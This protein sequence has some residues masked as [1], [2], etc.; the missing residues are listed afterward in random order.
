VDQLAVASVLA[1]PRCLACGRA[2]RPSARLCDRCQPALAEARPGAAALRISEIRLEVRWAGEYAGV[3]RDL[4]VALK[5]ARRHAAAVPIAAAMAPLIPPGVTIV[6]VPAS[7]WRRRLRV[8]DSA[9][10]IARALGRETGLAVVPCLRRHGGRRQVGRSR[11]ERLAAPPRVRVSRT[12]PDAP[13]LVDDVFTTGATL[14]AC[15]RALGPA[16]VGA[17]VFA[18][19]VGRRVEAA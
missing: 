6:P 18:H 7:P 10:E 19:G 17:A 12:L 16:V 5:F 14:A 11:A 1:P 3:V 13:L 2:T 8:F 15:A 9:E 4:I